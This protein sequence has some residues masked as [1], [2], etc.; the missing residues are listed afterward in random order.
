MLSLEHTKEIHV[1]ESRQVS[2]ERMLTVHWGMMGA[3]WDMM[4]SSMMD[5]YHKC[6]RDHRNQV[7]IHVRKNSRNLLLYYDICGSILHYLL[8]IH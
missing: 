6:M 1:Q 7:D 5:L 2:E 4:G 3:Y 8:H